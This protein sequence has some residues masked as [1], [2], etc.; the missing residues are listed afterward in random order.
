MLSSQLQ[1]SLHVDPSSGLL[2]SDLPT[3]ML[4]ITD[5]IFNTKLDIFLYFIYR[6]PKKFLIDKNR[7]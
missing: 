5:P 4:C 6:A 7:S 2:P 1:I 3:K